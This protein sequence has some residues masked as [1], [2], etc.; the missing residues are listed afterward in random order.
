[1]AARV[2]MRG[3]IESSLQW[4]IPPGDPPDWRVWRDR[5]RAEPTMSVGLGDGSRPS[6]SGSGGA[7]Y[8][9]GDVCRCIRGFVAWKDPSHRQVAP[10]LNGS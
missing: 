1:M 2:E 10:I 7:A 6:F 4:P 3:I 5:V 9:S 8:A